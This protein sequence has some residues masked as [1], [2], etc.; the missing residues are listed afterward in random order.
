MTLAVFDL[1]STLLNG[2]SD[3]AWGEFLARKGI[4]D[5]AY[6]EGNDR[7]YREYLA[8]NLDV[9]EYIEF[10]VQPLLSFDLSELNELRREFIRDSIQPMRLPKAESLLAEHRGWGHILVII[11]STTRL[12]TEP[13]A[14][15]LGVEHLLAT[16][17]ETEGG[18]L[19]GRI[20]GIP[21][22]GPNKVLKLNDWL[23]STGH[24]LDG[25]FFYS[26]S[27]TDLPLLELVHNPVAVDPDSTLHA[28]AAS[29]GWPVI[30]LR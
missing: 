26:D 13:I 3:H 30:S 9:R 11:T 1:D 24:S 4:V 29:R 14:R 16:D 19:T 25:S 28:E 7:F 6:K 12:I 10:M 18:R 22:F 8:G 2:D 21:C 15:L 5:R 17:L 23:R 27:H 20:K